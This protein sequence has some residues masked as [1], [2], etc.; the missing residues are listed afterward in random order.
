MSL[1]DVQRDKLIVVSDLRPH[2]QIALVV[3]IRTI[4]SITFLKQF[5]LHENDNC[6]YMHV[7]VNTNVLACD[8]ISIARVLYISHT[9]LGP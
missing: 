7:I 4:Y 1:L 8:E 2:I 9:I 5:L 6:S 3:R